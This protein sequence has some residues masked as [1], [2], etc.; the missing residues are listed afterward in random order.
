[1]GV[2]TSRAIGQPEGDKWNDSNAQTLCQKRFCAATQMARIAS[3]S[4]KGKKSVTV[5]LTFNTVTHSE[6]TH[7]SG[8]F[9]K[10]Y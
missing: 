2:E 3:A 4:P 5:T 6:I 9:L 8:C 7:R 1:M 10:K